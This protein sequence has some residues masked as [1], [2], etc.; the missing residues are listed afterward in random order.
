MFAIDMLCPKRSLFWAAMKRP[1]FQEHYGDAA[2]QGNDLK[3]PRTAEIC[4][5]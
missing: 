2:H 3:R 5:E 1:M 4:L